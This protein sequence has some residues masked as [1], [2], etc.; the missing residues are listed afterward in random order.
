MVITSLRSKMCETYKDLLLT[1]MQRDYVL[2][3]DLSQINFNDDSKFLPLNTMYL[4]V[5]VMQKVHQSKFTPATLTDS[6]IRC[7]KCLQVACGEMKKRF[8]FDDGLLVHIACLSPATATDVSVSS[9]E[10]IATSDR[11]NRC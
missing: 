7:Q 11:L 2:H 8:D 1:F 5:K 3:T 6:Y 4:G 10:S 9:H